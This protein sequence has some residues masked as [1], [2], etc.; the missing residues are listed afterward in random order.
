MSQEDPCNPEP[1]ELTPEQEKQNALYQSRFEALINEIDKFVKDMESVTHKEI[2]KLLNKTDNSIEEK[3]TEKETV[4]RE[5]TIR[6]AA[7]CLMDFAKKQ[8][9]F[10]HAGFDNNMDSLILKKKNSLPKD[11]YTVQYTKEYVFGRLMRQVAADFTI[12]E[13]A[14]QTRLMGTENERIALAQADI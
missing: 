13:R 10:F 7:K 9:E 1:K 11:E 5:N 4:R 3:E 2:I 12:I 14:Y 6:S 8:Y